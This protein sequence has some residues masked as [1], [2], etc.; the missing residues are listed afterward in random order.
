MS[1]IVNDGIREFYIFYEEIPHA[2]KAQNEHKQIKTKTVLNAHYYN[3]LPLLQ[4]IS[5]TTIFF[6]Q[7]NIFQ[8]PQ[9]FSIIIIFFNFFAVCN[10]IFMEINKRI[11]SII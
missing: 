4:C 5:I 10:T 6:N 7:H 2:Q 11:N 1:S 3:I 9:Y 8:S